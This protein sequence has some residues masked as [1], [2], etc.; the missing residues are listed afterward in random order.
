[1]IYLDSSVA[2]AQLLAEDRIPPPRLWQE[3][4]VASRLLEYELWARINARGLAVTHGELVRQLIGK[5]PLLEL[6][7]AVLERALEPF[8]SDVRTLDAL[9]LASMEFLRK[10]GQRLS[11]ASYDGRMLRCAR[12][13]DIPIYEI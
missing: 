3:N 11:L 5:L 1:M 13:L 6:S 10:N 7:P 2:M 8:P 12:L 9:H 4:L